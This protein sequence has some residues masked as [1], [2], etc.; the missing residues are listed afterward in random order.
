MTALDEA[1]L[2]R[3]ALANPQVWEYVVTIGKLLDIDADYIPRVIADLSPTLRDRLEK[4]RSAD[5]K[6]GDK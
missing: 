1:T 5:A 6:T 4:Q 2:V 3:K